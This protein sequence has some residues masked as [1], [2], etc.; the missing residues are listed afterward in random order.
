M[1]EEKQRIRTAKDAIGDAQRDVTDAIAE[2]A[3]ADRADKRH[4]SDRLKTALERL[5]AAHTELTRLEALLT[6]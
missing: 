2:I 6:R 1:D 3:A 5:R 4:V